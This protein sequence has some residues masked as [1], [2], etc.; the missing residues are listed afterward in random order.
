VPRTT[1]TNAQHGARRGGVRRGST[2]QYRATDKALIEATYRLL[3]TSGVE[4][5]SINDILRESG[6]S[7][8]AFYHHFES[9][10]ELLLKLVRE[11]YERTVARLSRAV[12]AAGSPVDGVATWIDESLAAAYEPRRAK[13]AMVFI[14]NDARSAPGFRRIVGQGARQHTAVLA[15]VLRQGKE[16]GV[17][18]LADPDNDAAAFYAVV[19]CIIEARLLGEPGPTRDAA[20]AHTLGLFLRALGARR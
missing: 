15:E 17:F 19:I 13:R 5:T 6:L 9:K 12:A 14:A 4:G 11:E 10:D 1:P 3:H 8:R 16:Q 7:T 18:P 20:R 2:A